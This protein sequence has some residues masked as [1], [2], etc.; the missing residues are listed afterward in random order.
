MKAPL[1]TVAIAFYNNA[2]VLRDAIVSVFNQT[3]SDWELLLMD[4]GSSDGSRAIAE[5]Y[6]GPRVRVLGDGQNRGLV[7]RL[8]QIAKEAR[9]TYLARMDGDDVMHPRRFEVQLQY[10]HDHPHVDLVDSAMISI[11]E[12][13]RIVGERGR[14]PR[15][16]TLK[17]V[18]RGD[19]PYHA[20]VLGRTSWFLANPYD[21]A[22]LRVEDL[23]LWC[24]TVTRSSFAHI[25]EPLYFVREGQIKVRN[26]SA[27]MAGVRRVNARYGPDVL[28]A[29]EVWRTQGCTYLKEWV[30]RSAGVFALHGRLTAM[31]N[32]PLSTAN[33]EQ[34]ERMFR[35]ATR[36]PDAA[37]LQS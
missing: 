36:E 19:T 31:R 5:R 20:T 21:P 29:A 24:R 13:G 2:V 28:G 18:L 35:L 6:A 14:G 7:A 12:H 10:L 11:D 9:G 33:H 27:A 37:A 15:L 16:F 30:Y 26:Y 4:D 8:N 22:Y 32:A 17:G 25:E 1:I 23:E 3:Y 34:A